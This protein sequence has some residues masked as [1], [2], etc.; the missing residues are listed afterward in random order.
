M[1][2]FRL[3]DSLHWLAG[4]MAGLLLHECPAVI[5]AYPAFASRM[6]S[7]YDTIMMGVAS[8][9]LACLSWLAGRTM[10]HILSRI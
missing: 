9:I 6:T 7:A 10:Q 3:G 2:A 5:F 1:F 8:S 4:T